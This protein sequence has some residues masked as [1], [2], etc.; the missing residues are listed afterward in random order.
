MKDP[1][2]QVLEHFATSVQNISANLA[3][4]DWGQIR[5]CSPVPATTVCTAQ[6]LS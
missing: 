1:D 2:R 3:V 5:N 4:S 6:V